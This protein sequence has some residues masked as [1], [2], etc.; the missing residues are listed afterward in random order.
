MLYPA[1]PTLPNPPEGYE[2]FFIN[3]LGRHG[4]RYPTS[5]VHLK[6]LSQRLEQGVSRQQLTPAGKVLLTHVRQL[7]TLF[8]G[9]WGE[10]TETGRVEQQTIARRM[11][12]HFPELFA[13]NN[14]IEAYS[15]EKNRCIASMEAFCQTLLQTQPRLVLRQTSGERHNDILRFFDRDTAYVEYKKSGAWKPIYEAFRNRKIPTETA[16]R[17]VNPNFVW[18]TDDKKKFV[19]ALFEAATLLPC[20]GRPQTF[21]ADFPSHERE[22]LWQIGNLRQYLLKSAAPVGKGV[23]VEIATPLLENFMATSDSV[24]QGK[25]SEKAVLRFAHAETVIPF[26]TLMQI[27]VADR[28]IA[29]ADSVGR[30]WQDFEISPMA[31]NIQWIFYRRPASPDLVLFL[32]N[33]RPVRLPID[34]AAPPFYTWDDVRTFFQEIVNRT[35]SERSDF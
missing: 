30:Y 13:P 22:A 5:D 35:K 25:K 7:E 17:F 27:T 1:P 6:Q 32:L 18:T 14:R 9:Q 20:T 31:A 16:D 8:N 10:L 4:A 19:E 26:A 28:S 23:P 15:T 34:P 11:Y 2:P 33:E 21:L 3:H 12:E 29:E 24:L